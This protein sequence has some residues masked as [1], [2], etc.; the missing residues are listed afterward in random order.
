MSTPQRDPELAFIWL[1]VSDLQRAVEF[2]RGPLGLPVQEPRQN[3]AIVHLGNTR[4][5]LAAGTPREGGMYL[6]LSFADVDALHRRLQEYDIPAK[7]PIDEGWARY[8]DVTDP[9]G[10]RLLLMGPPTSS[11]DL[12]S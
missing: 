4:I 1:E 12:A 7:P 3:L 11:H 9:D 8:I 6:A 5:Y 10:H 2:Y